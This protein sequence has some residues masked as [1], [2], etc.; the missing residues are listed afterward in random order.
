MKEAY[1]SILEGFDESPRRAWA[2]I[3]PILLVCG[4]LLSFCLW[5]MQPIPTEMPT[6]ETPRLAEAAREAVR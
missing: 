2:E 4:L 1:R 5:Y 3:L 6:R